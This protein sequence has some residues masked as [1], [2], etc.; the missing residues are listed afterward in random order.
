MVWWDFFMIQF[1]VAGV[2]IHCCSVLWMMDVS[3]VSLGDAVLLT[4]IVVE[5]WIA[6]VMSHKQEEQRSLTSLLE[7]YR[8]FNRFYMRLS[9]VY[10]TL[11]KHWRSFL[12]FIQ[13]SAD[14][15]PALWQ[16]LWILRCHTCLFDS[17]PEQKR[18]WLWAAIEG[19]L[20]VSVMWHDGGILERGGL[21]QSLLE[22]RKCHFQQL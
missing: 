4:G 10:I 5:W 21:I 3:V 22:V 12:F 15:V 19:T 11:L 2:L 6:M 8:V 18:I 1:V 20:S 9:F 7:F 14:I 17:C 13:C 16:I